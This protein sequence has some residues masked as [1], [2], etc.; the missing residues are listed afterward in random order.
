VFTYH[1][2]FNPTEVPEI[3]AGCESGALGC[4]D[5]KMRAA[6]RIIEHLAPIRERRLALEAHPETVLDV[7][8]DGN[9]RAREVAAKTMDQVHD[10]MG[11]G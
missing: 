2:K 5:C 8:T 1:T 3:R 6:N 11:F 10:A 9:D 4:V 7:I